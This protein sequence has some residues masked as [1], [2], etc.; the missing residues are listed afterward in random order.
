MLRKLEADGLVIASVAPGERGPRRHVYRLTASGRR[1]LEKKLVDAIA[2]VRLAYL[3][4]LAGD[5]PTMDRALALLA[6]YLPRSRPR[7]RSA[8]V[9]PPGYLSE[10][11]FRWFLGQL[12]DV[13]Q[14]ELYLVRPQ[15]TFEIDEPRLTLLDGSEAYVPLRDG[16]VDNLI[17]V[18]VPRR[19][20]WSRPLAECSRVLRPPGLLG[21]ILPDALLARDVR[22]P[23]E[24]GA[25]M[26]GIRVKRT[27]GDVAEVQ[28]ERAVAFLEERFRGVAVEPVPE[29]SF[30][31][32][33]AWDKIP[34]DR[35][36]RTPGGLRGNRRPSK[37]S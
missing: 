19:R 20:Q 4:H 23:I 26:E 11:N 1:V 28:L 8:M 32:L 18:W 35:A 36:A 15:G 34:A 10:V 24:I 5:V 27:G 7:G 31:L 3:E 21:V 33:I 25:F 22:R 17:L 2:V 12:L 16:H 30:H 13:V 37:P 14:G 29:L 6:K 9:V